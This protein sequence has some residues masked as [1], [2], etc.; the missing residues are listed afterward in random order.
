MLN[1]QRFWWVSYEWKYAN[2]KKMY[3]ETICAMK[4]LPQKQEKIWMNTDE[5]I[6]QWVR[7]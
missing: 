7:L 6:K 1:I 3:T 4:K 2:I 5:F